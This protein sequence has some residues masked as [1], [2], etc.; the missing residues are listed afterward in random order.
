[1]VLAISKVKNNVFTIPCSAREAKDVKYYKDL[2]LAAKMFTYRREERAMDSF[3]PYRIGGWMAYLQ[4]FCKRDTRLLSHTWS[5]YFVPACLL[6][7]FQPY[8]DS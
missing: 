8:G 6:A 3:V 1:M 2:R 5:E 7:I 4:P